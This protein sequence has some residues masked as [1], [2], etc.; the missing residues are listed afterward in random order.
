MP[1]AARQSELHATIAGNL[2]HVR[3][4]IAE[5]AGRSGR[6]ADEVRL[7]AAT[8][9]VGLAEARALVA[10]GCRDLGESRPQELWHKTAELANSKSE[11]P[12]LD[13]EISDL[14]SE[15]SSPA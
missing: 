8:N 13:S 9:Y 5:A 7:I 15:I 2:A 12:N 14:K 10:A 1:D 11:L 4:R 6:K 3:Q